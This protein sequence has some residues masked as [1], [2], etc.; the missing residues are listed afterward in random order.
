MPEE[1]GRRGPGSPAPGGEGE[2]VWWECV[3]QKAVTLV[4]P[5][6]RVQVVGVRVLSR[7]I[8]E[9]YK[10]QGWHFKARV[11]PP[12]PGWLCFDA[13]AGRGAASFCCLSP[14]LVLRP[15]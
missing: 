4:F 13:R 9:S 12:A 3:P 5:S 10:T 15:P 7:L 6:P 1:D 8:P 2:V 11:S 14:P